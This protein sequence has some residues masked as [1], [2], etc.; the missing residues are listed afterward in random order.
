VTDHPVDAVVIPKLRAYVMI[1]KSLVFHQ[2]Q[3]V[4]D[5]TCWPS[6]CLF[7]LSDGELALARSAKNLIL[8]PTLTSFNIVC[9][10]A[11]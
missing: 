9:S 8:S 1:N 2:L 11:R 10:G 6:S 3:A 7:D 4:E 5:I